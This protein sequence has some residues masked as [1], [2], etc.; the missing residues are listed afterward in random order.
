MKKLLLLPIA[1]FLTLFLSTL[2]YAYTIDDN[3]KVLQGYSN[4]SSYGTWVDVIPA[5]D[6]STYN[7]WGIDANVN[8]GKLIL[9]I[10]TNLPAGGTIDAFPADLA[11]DVG[12][13]LDGDFEFGVAFSGETGKT[14]GNLY[15]VSSWK[16]S[17]EYFEDKSGLIYGEK[18]NNPHKTTDPN[19]GNE[20]PL[21]TINGTNGPS[22][23]DTG[24]TWTDAGSNPNERI[25][26]EIVLSALGI[27]P[28]QTKDIGLFLAA[29]NC[30]N[31]IIYG[32]IEVTNVPIPTAVLF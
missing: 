14:T 16:S 32:E 15:S 12:E 11:I 5:G 1:T 8:N 28:G 29:A 13:S 3:T 24:L 22:L 4:S 7:L 27:D 23:G 19:L 6:G 20:R 26:L 17:Y 18:W 25:H 31:D 10:Y 21:V 9:D 2:T 30:A